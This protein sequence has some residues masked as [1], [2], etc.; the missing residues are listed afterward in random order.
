MAVVKFRVVV[1]S[2]GVEELR[3]FE[4]V[5][6]SDALA[7]AYEEA[8]SFVEGLGL[9][10]EG[11]AGSV[12]FSQFDKTLGLAS[13][14]SVL[15]VGAVDVA[16]SRFLT[17]E[18]LRATNLELFAACKPLVVFPGVVL[19]SSFKQQVEHL[20]RFSELSFASD[21]GSVFPLVDEYVKFYDGVVPYNVI[22]Y[23][24]FVMRDLLMVN[25]AKLGLD[26]DVWEGLFYLTEVA[27]NMV[28]VGFWKGTGGKFN[29]S[30]K[31][32]VWLDVR[33]G[34]LAE[35]SKKGFDVELL[36]EFTGDV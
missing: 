13:S 8:V 29:P 34:L 24:G 31:E 2:L 21:S 22:A 5:S 3:S 10:E 36:T 30:A 28:Q 18:L 6:V 15:T 20:A 33:A 12:A 17:E 16:A 25:R 4:W 35:V 7:V 26:D 23:W 19:G 9:A 1:P 14:K 11:V 27:S 32:L